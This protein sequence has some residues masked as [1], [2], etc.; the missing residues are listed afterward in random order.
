MSP[1]T[2]EPMISIEADNL[3]RHPLTRSKPQD[4]VHVRLS[5]TRNP[6]S[7]H[8][9]NFLAR[10]NEFYAQSLTT[11]TRPHRNI[12]KIW[13]WTDKGNS[14]SEEL[15]EIPEGVKVSIKTRNVVVEGE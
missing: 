15:L 3:N 11:T 1:R 4:E 14:H 9:K 12:E 8:R 2:F 7:Q 10:Y 5:A 13:T 6:A